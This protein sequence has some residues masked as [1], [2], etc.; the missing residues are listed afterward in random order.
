MVKV[1]QSNLG[2]VIDLTAGKCDASVNYGAFSFDDIR[3]LRK[4]IDL[5]QAIENRSRQRSDGTRV[6]KSRKDRPVN[7]PRLKRFVPGIALAS[8][9]NPVSL[10]GAHI[11]DS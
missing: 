6:L 5:K 2:G 9:S 10:L 3:L 8:S 4:S 11:V 1:D 7:T